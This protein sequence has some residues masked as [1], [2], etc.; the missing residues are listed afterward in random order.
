MYTVK[1]EE[2]PEGDLSLASSG[3]KRIEQLVKLLHNTEKGCVHI[4]GDVFDDRC[5]CA[6]SILMAGS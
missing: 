6:Q 1:S 2:N 3:V 4:V 5:V